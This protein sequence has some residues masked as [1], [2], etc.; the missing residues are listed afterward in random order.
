MYRTVSRIQSGKSVFLSG[1]DRDLAVF[2]KVQLGSEA[3]SGFEYGT[4]HSFRVVQGVS[5]LRSSLGG[6]F[7]LFIEDQHGRQA[8]H[9]VVR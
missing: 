8:S 6:K 7:G 4:L 9:P 1:S 2:I 5:G 3:L